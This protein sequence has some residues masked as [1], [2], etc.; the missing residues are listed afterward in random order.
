MKNRL[1]FFMAFSLFM[2]YRI[3]NAELPIKISD[4]NTRETIEY[5]DIKVNRA[6][7][8]SAGPQ[9]PAGA[10]GAI[11]PEGPA[12]PA[13]PQG[14][15]GPIGSFIAFQNEDFSTLTS[16][17]TTN[18]T[19]ANTPVAN[20]LLLSEN[21]VIMKSTADYSLNGNVVSR[22][23]ASPAGT[24]LVASYAVPTASFTIMNTTNT[25]T[26]PN[27]Y[28]S[29]A[30]FTGRVVAS[31][32]TINNFLDIG[33]EYIRSA[34]CGSFQCTAYCSAGKSVLGGGCEHYIG[35]GMYVVVSV[36]VNGNS[37][38]CSMSNTGDIYATAIC[39]KVK[40]P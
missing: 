17:T 16:P 39:A 2:A 5:L 29:T 38:Y 36:P 28:T 34:N 26:A 7:T 22:V 20:S 21:G 4:R 8:T 32:V 30:T 19:L 35:P 18:F 15:Q 37:W 27:S 31:S 11:G 13:G 14:E 9:G 3:A 23:S 12:G 25:W 1:F 40:Y 33:L 6:L 24:Y 10:D